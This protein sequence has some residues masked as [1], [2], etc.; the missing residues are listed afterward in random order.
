VIVPL[1]VFIFIIGIFPQPFFNTMT[2]SVNAL[3]QGL[4]G[5]VALR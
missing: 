4:G 1:V 2:A 3:L 5:A